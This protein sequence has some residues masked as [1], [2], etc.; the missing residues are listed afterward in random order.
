VYQNRRIG[1]HDRG[2]AVWESRRRGVVE[3]RAPGRRVL[4]LPSHRVEGGQIRDGDAVRPRRERRAELAERL[5]R[6]DSGR[7]RE[8]G[9]AR[10]SVRDGDVL[11]FERDEDDGVDGEKVRSRFTLVPIRPRRR[12]ERRSLRTFLPGVSLRPPLAFDPRHRRLSTPLLTPFN[13]NAKRYA[14]TTAGAIDVASAVTV[15]LD[16]A[17]FLAIDSTTTSKLVLA[18]HALGRDGDTLYSYAFAIDVSDANGAAKASIDLRRN[19]SP[20]AGMVVALPAKGVAAQT[21]F[22]IAVGDGTLDP[23]GHLPLMIRFTALVKGAP[24]HQSRLLQDYR[25]VPSA[26]ANVFHPSIAF[27]IY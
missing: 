1:E 20:V 25:R 21:T 12:G 10:A 17:G 26:R 4:R 6:A 11:R 3:L 13:S 27:L 19:V 9:I 14:L 24:A 18:P 22:A 5:D 23:D 15:D 7:S 8:R 16:A 2:N